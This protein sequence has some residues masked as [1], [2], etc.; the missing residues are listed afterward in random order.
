MRYHE[1]EATIAGITSAEGPFPVLE[2]VIDG[3]IGQEPE[4]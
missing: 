3:T 4:I 2:K 1:V